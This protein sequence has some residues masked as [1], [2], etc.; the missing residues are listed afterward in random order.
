MK[1]SQELFVECIRQYEEK[2][3]KANV[4]NQLLQNPFIMRYKGVRRSKLVAIASRDFIDE[5]V[6]RIRNYS[7]EIIEKDSSLSDNVDVYTLGIVSDN[8][9][10]SYNT[11]YQEKGL[12][13]SIIDRLQMEEIKEFDALFDID[14]VKNNEID[15]SLYDYLSMSNDTTDAKNSIFYALLLMTVYQNQPVSKDLLEQLMIDRYG[16]NV[17]NVNL[18]L[19][20]LR[21]GDRIAPSGKGNSISLTEDEKVR[22][23]RSLKEEQS[24]EADFKA[25]YN[26]ILNKYSISDGDQ[27]L[28][29]L[30]EAYQ[31]QYQWHSRSG[32]D[33]RAKDEITKE[34]YKRIKEAVENKIGENA[35]EFISELRIL[36][37]STEYLTRYCLSHSFLQLFRS[38]SYEKYITNKGSVIFLDTSVITYYLCYLT[39]LEEEYSFIWDNP[40]Y[41][42][43]KSLISI[44]RG[45]NEK[46]HFV[47]PYDYLQETVGE[48]KKAL[49]FSW[50]EKIDLP[51]P[52]ETGNTFYNFYNALNEAL[53]ERDEENTILTFHEFASKIG[54]QE[55]NPNSSLFN[56]KTFIYLKYFF[57]KFGCEILDP[58]QDRY[59]QFDIVRDAYSAQLCFKERKKTAVAMNSDVRQAFYIA[60]E[61]LDDE[62]KDNDYFLVT[63]DKT[64]R[65]VRD[66]VNDELAIV[67]S[68]GIMNPTNLANK[69]ALRHFQISKSN[70]SDDVFA[71]AESEFNFA[72]KVQSLYD[73]VL[74][75]YFANS[76]NTNS[77]LVISI[78]RM[79][80]NCQEVDVK[81]EARVKENTILADIF[82]PIVYALP[83]YDLSAQNLR[84][85]LADE[86]NNEFVIGLFTEAFDANVKGGYVDISGRFCQ[87]VKDELIKYDKEIRL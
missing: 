67:S 45:K 86:S 84:D 55:L 33:E 87:H 74:T 42:S 81:D 19:K 2:V 31:A 23:E 12:S 24:V 7:I 18:A 69:M 53:I 47:I 4:E 80:K 62:Y 52:F 1:I 8:Q 3:L 34:H 37:D 43:V 49:Q 57:E 20:E 83:D 35:N 44:K 39:G 22:L 58:I 46:I 21:R 27:I 65:G 50:F 38:P 76:N 48:V 5:E 13:L 26:S 51:I 36:C 30:R 75:P 82:L 68:Y 64:L 72:K 41:Q 11:M 77:S 54:F 9:R 66:L 70:V 32:D 25:R 63:W 10:I 56:K 79:E 78:L 29:T 16:K 73:T 71:Y 59:N 85:F 17:G 14:G 60:N 61:Y 6:T 28:S 40:E 15:T